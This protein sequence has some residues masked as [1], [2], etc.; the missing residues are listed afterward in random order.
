MKYEIPFA[1][2]MFLYS[3]AD[4]EKWDLLQRLYTDNYLNAQPAEKIKIP[5]IIHQIW[6]GGALPAEKIPSGLGIPP[7]DRRKRQ[8]LKINKSGCF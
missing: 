8:R 1:N 7:L 2:G 5:K 6:L 3:T 4:A